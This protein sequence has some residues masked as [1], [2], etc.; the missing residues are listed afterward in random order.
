MQTERPP[1][2]RQKGCV[3]SVT[4]QSPVRVRITSLAAGV[5]GC[6]LVCDVQPALTSLTFMDAAKR[7]VRARIDGLAPR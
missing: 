4:Q 6:D 2:C 3:F 7:A 5:G 1:W